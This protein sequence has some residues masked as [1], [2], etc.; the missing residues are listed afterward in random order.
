[1]LLAPLLAF[2][3]SLAI[4]PSRDTSPTSD[5]RVVGVWK[6]DAKG[7]G[8]ILPE[9]GVPLSLWI[10][11]GEEGR[12][13][14]RIFVQGFDAQEARGSFDADGGSLALSGKFGGAL[15]FALKARVEGEALEG[16]LSGMGISIALAARR[17]S[18]DVLSEPPVPSAPVALTELD[19][20][21]WRADLRF[22]ASYL[23]QVHANAFH[24]RSAEDWRR[25]VSAL[26]QRLGELDGL[27]SAL[28]LAQLVASVGDA[29]TEL[30]W[31]ALGGFDLAP[32]RFESFA[33]GLFVTEIAADQAAGL[34]A[35]VVRVGTLG[36]DEALARVERLFSAENESWK[37]AKAPSLLA[38]PRLLH[39]LG[40][41]EAPDRLMVSVAPRSDAPDEL[42]EVALEARAGGARLAAPD[43]ELDA[44]PLWQT[45]TPENYWRSA[46]PD[47]HAIYFAYNR[48]AED[49]RHPIAGFVDELLAE[50]QA[51]GAERL[52]ID[53][54]H[55]AGGNS[56]VL[57]AHVA[58]IA[59]PPKLAARGHLVAL[60]GP[61]TFSSGVLNAIELRNAGALLVGEPTG[62]KPN[63]YGELRSFRLPHSGLAVY[64][65][66]KFF[67]LVDGDP[68]SLEPDVLVPLHSYEAFAGEDPVLE[69]AL[70]E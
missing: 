14:A 2:A 27:A 17:I 39:A 32:V 5:E 6:G 53:L 24:A 20:E 61:G 10:E 3:P 50:L 11:S 60:I 52:V 69:R 7:D 29:H 16:E 70:R 59:A 66:T 47:A 28:A 54:R 65:S 35:R 34:G 8:G 31:R 63:S 44:L 45:R 21:D 58:R 38:M 1:M 25:D 19:A 55:N 36:V 68:P 22:L 9:T 13:V 40:C 33:D 46:L 4:D 43:P 30:D 51:S 23:P 12:L 37:R 57:S 64:Y 15:P 26:D 56:A 18:R 48:C 67:R 41:L 62:G 42:V 49:P